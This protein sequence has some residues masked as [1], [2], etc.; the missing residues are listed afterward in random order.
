ME[1]MNVVRSMQ[2]KGP[3]YNNNARNTALYVI[4][5]SFEKVKSKSGIATKLV[6]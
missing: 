4:K 3:I 2:G 6:P 5:F 1:F